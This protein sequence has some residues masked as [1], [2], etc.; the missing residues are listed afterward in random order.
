MKE[1]QVLVRTKKRRHHHKKIRKMC[2]VS[3]HF[4]KFVLAAMCVQVV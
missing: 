1:K 3:N 2:F 4:I